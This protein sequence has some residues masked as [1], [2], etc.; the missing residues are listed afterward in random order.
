VFGTSMLGHTVVGYTYLKDTV[1]INTDKH[2]I[3]N[4]NTCVNA[5][6]KN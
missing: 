4:V 1:Y 6:L 3:N 5:N 2:T